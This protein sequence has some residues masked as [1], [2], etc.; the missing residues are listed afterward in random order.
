M[1]PFFVYFHAVC[2]VMLM[3]LFIILKPSHC[4]LLVIGTNAKIRKNL[5]VVSTICFLFLKDLLINIAISYRHFHAP[6]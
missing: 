1:P 3:M 2:S 6:G 4:S 5:S